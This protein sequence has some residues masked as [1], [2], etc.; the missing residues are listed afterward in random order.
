M[1]QDHS[2]N[3]PVCPCDPISKDNAAHSSCLWV[4][5]NAVLRKCRQKEARSSAQRRPTLAAGIPHTAQCLRYWIL[6]L[7]AKIPR[8][9]KQVFGLTRNNPNSHLI[10]GYAEHKGCWPG[11]G[12]ICRV[13]QRSS[14]RGVAVPMAMISTVSLRPVRRPDRRSPSPGSL[15]PKSGLLTCAQAT[16]GWGGP[17]LQE[18]GRP[19]DSVSAT[20]TRDQS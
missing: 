11:G 7:D 18:E 16:L 2:P 10:L 15:A 12:R 17:T 9:R 3:T 19:Q 1:P 5:S 8:E 20:G 4:L 13:A 14:R 6:V